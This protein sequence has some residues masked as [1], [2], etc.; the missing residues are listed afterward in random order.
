MR[1]LTRELSLFC[2]YAV[3][4][5]IIA[6]AQAVGIR[7]QPVEPEVLAH[8]V[9]EHCTCGT[10]QDHLAELSVGLQINAAVVSSLQASALVALL[11]TKMDEIFHII[12]GTVH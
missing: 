4:A 2:L 1:N 5:G 9:A 12:D 7:L 3:E 10:C 11:E 8:L 6:P